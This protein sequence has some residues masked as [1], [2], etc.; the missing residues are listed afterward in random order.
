MKEPEQCLYDL[1]KIEGGAIYLKRVGDKESFSRS[2]VLIIPS[3]ID[4]FFEMGELG[5]LTGEALALYKKETN[6]Y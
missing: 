4:S 3:F 6:E 5:Y 2:E 1:K